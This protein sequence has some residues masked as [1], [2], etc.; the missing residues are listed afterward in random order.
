MRKTL[1]LATAV[2]VVIT[3]MGAVAAPASAVNRSAC[4][5]IG[6]YKALK[7][8]A[9]KARVRKLLDGKGKRVDGRTRRY[10]RCGSEAQVYVVFNRPYSKKKAALAAF[11]TSW[12]APKP[13][14]KPPVTP[15]VKPPVVPPAPQVPARPAPVTET[16]SVIDAGSCPTLTVTYR[17][18]RRTNS[19]TW[20]AR[21]WVP[22][23]SE[24][25]TVSSGTRS[26]TAR[27]CVNVVD[28]LASDV[29][30]PD[31]RIKN[32][33]Q[34]GD[35]DLDATNG[36]CFTIVNPAPRN[37][38]F[39]QL[40]GKKLL[41]FPVITLNVGAGPSE[42]IADRSGPTE[43]AW[44]AYQTFYRPNGERQSQPIPAVTFYYAGDGHDH[45]H[46][47]DFD[48]YWIESLD[49]VVVRTAEK[50]GYCIQDNTEWDG[51]PGD[52]GVPD[53]P[54]YTAGT[55]CGAGLPNSLTIIQ[56]L[57]RGWGDTYDT[58]LP[59]QAIDI[60]GLPNGRYRVGITADNLGAVRESDET[61]NTAV[62]EISISGDSVTTYPS[63][64]TG[65][66][67]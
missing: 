6:E 62:M 53:A 67:D 39:P 29:L 50:H 57:S 66:L 36:T 40:R 28:H 44:K 14:A 38:D 42:V 56:G 20:A 26:A 11:R 61:N 7:V 17:N 59:D 34:C 49:G 58:S 51:F 52:P 19:W 21:A 24:W 15:P 47:K 32:L 3:G 54:V 23:W 60:T 63:T 30:L 55:S 43:S 5:T 4:V 27:D 64:A 18:Q 25:L 45:W 10:Q 33:D 46:F 48:S 31:I 16:R 41:K 13:R 37:P 12:P 35:Y 2:V 1:A 65:G 9:S 22:A 8:G